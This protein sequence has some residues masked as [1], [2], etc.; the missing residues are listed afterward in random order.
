MASFQVEPELLGRRAIEADIRLETIF[1]ARP[2]SVP[3]RDPLP[4]LVRS[5]GFAAQAPTIPAVRFS[6]SASSKCSYG[7]RRRLVKP[8]QFKRVTACP[9][10]RVEDSSNSPDPVLAQDT[11]HE[12]E[13]W[14]DWITLEKLVS[15]CKFVIV[16]A[17][18]THCHLQRVFLQHR[19]MVFRAF[20]MNGHP[21]ITAHCPPRAR[22]CLIHGIIVIAEL[23]TSR[24]MDRF[25]NRMGHCT[26]IL[27]SRFDG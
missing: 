26:L 4:R 1:F 7:S 16:A 11:F 23:R 5:C 10:A 21:E 15:P 27:L 9:T 2:R 22:L 13:A 12:I 24:N 8:G 14:S 19:L 6:W 18:T 25:T 3:T 17:L 20:F